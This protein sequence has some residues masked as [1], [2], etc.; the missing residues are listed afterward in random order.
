MKLHIQ[1]KSSCDYTDNQVKGTTS[2]D[3]LSEKEV[4]SIRAGLSDLQ[5]GTIDFLPFG[6][7]IELL[8]GSEKEDGLSANP[9]RLADIKEGN[10]APYT[11]VGKKWPDFCQALVC[12]ESLPYGLKLETS[13]TWLVGMS[14]DFIKSIQKIDKKLSGRILDAMT[15]ICKTPV[16]PKGDTIKPLSSDLKG[17]WRYRIGDFRLVY[18]PDTAKKQVTLLSF[19]ARSNVYQ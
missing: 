12:E 15:H 8:E 10:L 19:N 2:K 3:R 17:L 1:K 18:K 9:D 16:T 14:E 7:F 13:S 6:S 4:A 11:E 5:K